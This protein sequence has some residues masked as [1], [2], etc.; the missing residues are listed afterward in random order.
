M[1]K[2]LAVVVCI[3]RRV[4]NCR[5]DRCSLAFWWLKLSRISSLQLHSHF[6][7]IELLNPAPMNGEDAGVD[8]SILMT[9]E[10]KPLPPLQAEIQTAHAA[11][12][13]PT[14][15]RR[16]NCRYIPKL[17]ILLDSL[18]F[19]QAAL[20]QLGLLTRFQRDVRALGVQDYASKPPSSMTNA[21]MQACKDYNGACNSMEAQIVR[22]F[23]LPLRR[24]PTETYFLRCGPGQHCSTKQMNTQVLCIPVQAIS[25]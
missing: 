4:L 13:V 6:V 11:F 23:H 15:T 22:L 7:D 17:T 25:T 2:S 14:A 18:V 19:D 12:K 3:Q 21:L 1:Q 9:K 10:T 8:R 5:H 24:S 20:L 16:Q